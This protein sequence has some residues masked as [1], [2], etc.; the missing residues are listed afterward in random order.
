MTL[1]KLI[2][3]T[4]P[5]R[6]CSSLSR[7]QKEAINWDYFSN[8]AN[9]VDIAANALARRVN[10]ELKTLIAQLHELSLAKDDP[11]K[12]QE[13]K[14]TLTPLLY[15][16]PN[17]THPRVR[18][19]KS[20]EPVVLEKVGS[21]PPFTY[22]PTNFDSL[23][24]RLNV[25]RTK[26]LGNISGHKS[27]YLKND[28]AM[29]EQALVRYSLAKL[30]KKN[31]LQVSVPDIISRDDIERCGMRT[32]NKHSQIFHIDEAWSPNVCLSGTS[33]ISLASYLSKKTFPLS[34][35]P[36]RFC[37]ASRCFRAEA[38]RSQKERGIFRVHQF[39]KVEMFGITPNESGQKSEELLYEFTSIQR[40]IFT[41]LG[42]HFKILEMPVVDLGLP[43]YHKID[44][45]AWIPTLKMFGEVS[46]ASNCTEYQ[47]RRMDIK[48][49]SEKPGKTKFCHTVNGTACAIP[50]L[51][52][53]ILENHQN[54]DGSVRVPEPLQ[55]Y[56]GKEVMKDK[57]QEVMLSTKP[58]P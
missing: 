10:C 21:K 13:L 9:F 19:N 50:R 57:F 3:R 30:R 51:L 29:L 27:Y 48:Y 23:T 40:E 36:L 28:L 56:M 55:K 20:E 31:F 17:D 53:A 1:L 5:T 37:A 52:I 43:A 2:Y 45:E 34:K 54:L 58:V 25:L 16:F 33:E 4:L 24:K 26:H 6:R 8:S 47:S 49:E 15:F 42:L 44:I 7:F 12:T 38:K 18:E 22:H 14:N 32:D 41:E 35:L 11:A 46:S 39:T